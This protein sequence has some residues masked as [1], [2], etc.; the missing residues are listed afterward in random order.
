MFFGDVR[1]GPKGL[2]S[3]RIY[4]SIYIYIYIYIYIDSL[5]LQYL[6][7]YLKKVVQYNW[8]ILWN[9]YISKLH[10]KMFFFLNWTSF[11]CFRHSIGDNYRVARQYFWNWILIFIAEPKGLNMKNISSLKMCAEISCVYPN[12]LDKVAFTP[13]YFPIDIGLTTSY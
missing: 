10:I 6:W 3:L 9:K 11:R 5:N 12:C 13:S 2:I 8:T 4:L 7:L 1:F